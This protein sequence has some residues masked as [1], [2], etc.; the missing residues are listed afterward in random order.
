M[1]KNGILCFKNGKQNNDDEPKERKIE[2]IL[3]RHQFRSDYKL[4]IIFKFNMT[5][6]KITYLF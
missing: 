1:F 2:E 5:F 4:K 3:E 6:K